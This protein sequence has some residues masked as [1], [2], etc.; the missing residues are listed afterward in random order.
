[1][2]DEAGRAGLDLKVVL[3]SFV[4]TAASVIGLLVS[5]APMSASLRRKEIDDPL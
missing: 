3:N 2:M 4:L 5:Q 1:M